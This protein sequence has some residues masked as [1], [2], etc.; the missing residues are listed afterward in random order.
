MSRTFSLPSILFEP[1]CVRNSYLVR[2]NRFPLYKVFLGKILL[3]FSDWGTERDTSTFPLCDPV[4]CDVYWQSVDILQTC[5]PLKRKAEGWG[6]RNQTMGTLG[7]ELNMRTRRKR[8]TD[9]YLATSLWCSVWSA[10]QCGQSKKTPLRHKMSE[11]LKRKKKMTP[12]SR[13]LKSALRF[14]PSMKSHQYFSFGS[15]CHEL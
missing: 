12:H 15:I 4:S 14:F 5:L 1:A 13:Q 3:I 10:P 8:K 2:Y 7:A 9:V 11:L 6:A